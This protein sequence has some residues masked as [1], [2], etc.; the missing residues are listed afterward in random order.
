MT[1]RGIEQDLPFSRQQ[2][3]AGRALGS[4][5]QPLPVSESRPD[6]AFSQIQPLRRCWLH[7]CLCMAFSNL[8]SKLFSKSDRINVLVC[9]HKVEATRECYSC[10]PYELLAQEGIVSDHNVEMELRVELTLAF[11]HYW[12]ILHIFSATGSSIQ[13]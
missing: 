1:A 4:A 5:F 12:T 6:S 7:R 9:G 11:L 10:R 3:A 13:G 8:E 2:S